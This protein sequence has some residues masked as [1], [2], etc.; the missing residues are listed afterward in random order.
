MKIGLI[1]T[2][3]VGSTTAYTLMLQGIA[4]ELVLIDKNQDKAQGETLDLIHS[5]SFIHPV[6]IYTGDYKDLNKAEIVIISAGP[7]ISKGETRLDLAVKN[8][9]ILKEIIPQI[10]NYNDNCILLVVTNPVDVLAY[11]ALKISGLDKSKVIGSGTVLDSSRFRSVISEKLEVDARNIHGYIIGEHGDSQVAAWSLTNIMGIQFDEFCEKHCENYDPA[12][13]K[14]ITDEVKNS[15]Y[16]VIEKKGA[17]SFAVALAIAKITKSILRDENSILTVSSYIDDPF[18]G[19]HDVF[20]SLP[21]VVN[22][23]G[24]SKTLKV[25]LSSK[26]HNALIKSA[27]VIKKFI[28][29][30]EI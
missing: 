22:R 5:M 17:T 15:A 21:C 20:L 30:I 27:E 8:Y 18:Y 4:S 1:G 16:K 7:S 26:E 6:E 29:K 3:Y 19:I 28:Q 24:V 23:K 10:M 2:G 25:P 11:A 13:K 9:N 14:E 12:V